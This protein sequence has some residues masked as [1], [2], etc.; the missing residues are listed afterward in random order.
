MH[1]AYTDFF[2]LLVVV[3]C[4][5]NDTS[6]KALTGCLPFSCIHMY[7]IV[8]VCHFTQKNGHW[9]DI[10]KDGWLGRLNTWMCMSLCASGEPCCVVVLTG[11][12]VSEH[13]SQGQLQHSIGLDRLTP[14]SDL[15]LVLH[16]AP[17]APSL[18][19]SVQAPSAW[20][21]QVWIIKKQ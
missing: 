2:C 17:Q 21:V 3:S 15:C 5:E 13:L 14:L 20:F 8:C 16:W 18:V 11:W 12:G 7:C 10:V 19:V 4:L 1:I 9:T 6:W